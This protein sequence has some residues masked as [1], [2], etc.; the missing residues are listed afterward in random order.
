[1]PR[2]GG[3]HLLGLEANATGEPPCTTEFIGLE[4]PREARGL[5]LRDLRVRARTSLPR[6][7]GPREGGGKA[8]LRF[9]S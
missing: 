2:A 4:A 5:R 8:A 6:T 1:M 9:R 3:R 7:E